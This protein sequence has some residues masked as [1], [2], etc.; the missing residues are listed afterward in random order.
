MY[1]ISE[2]LDFDENKTRQ[3]LLFLCEKLSDHSE[4]LL[5]DPISHEF[6]NEK[7]V[8][9]KKILNYS[10]EWTEY[11]HGQD[12]VSVSRSIIEPYIITYCKSLHMLINRDIKFSCHTWTLYLCKQCKRVNPLID[13]IQH[14]PLCLILTQPPCISD[15][16]SCIRQSCNTNCWTIGDVSKTNKAMVDRLQ[17]AWRRFGGVLCLPYSR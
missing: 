17:Q 2:L 15:W 5:V 6:Y 1:G 13:S 9:I 3:F 7:E 14:V 8:L 4:L 10:T 16:I 12:K 11:Y